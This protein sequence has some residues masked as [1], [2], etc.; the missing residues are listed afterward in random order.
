MEG[1]RI[2]SLCLVGG[3]SN[4]SPPL[5]GG[6]GGGGRNT[7][8]YDLQNSLDVRKDFIIPESHNPKTLA[9][10]P[11]VSPPVAF[12]VNGVLTAV[13]FDYEHFLKT[14]EINY[15]GSYGLLTTKFAAFQ[16]PVPKFRPQGLFGLS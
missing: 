16:L 13:H 12:P 6:V 2:I 4:V 1:S 15:V 10:K 5:L 11:A 9:C 8:S 7:L 3:R 14:D